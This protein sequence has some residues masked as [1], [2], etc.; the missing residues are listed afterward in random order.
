[1]ANLGPEGTSARRHAVELRALGRTVAAQGRLGAEA[2]ESTARLV[3]DMVGYAR[4]DGAQRV[5]LVATEAVR[6]AADGASLQDR[7]RALTGQR[8]HVLT[9]EAEA[10]LSYL[11]AT[12]F[13]VASGQAALVADVGG[14]STEVVP[15]QG[16]Q[17]APGVSLKLGSDRLLLITKADDP[18]T[19]RQR[20]DALARVSMVLEKAPAPAGTGPLIATGGTAANVPA[21]LGQRRRI[22]ESDAG[23]REEPPGPGWTRIE[24]TQLELAVGLTGRHPSAEVARRSGLSPAR[25]RLMAG[26]VLIL[27]G[28][29]DRYQVASVEVTERG[30]RDGVLLALAGFKPQA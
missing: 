23:L 20:A 19:A 2:V 30:L 29:L 7:V 10:R 24:R 28:L 1:M 14:A 22:C 11:G 25:A 15:G 3:E 9:G 4:T 26:G 12:A 6:Q 27:L 21:L 8:L 18:P 13:R 17:P 5:G 16:S